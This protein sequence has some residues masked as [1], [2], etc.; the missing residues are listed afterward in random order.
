MSRRGGGEA[1]IRWGDS[2]SPAV[3]VAPGPLLE[4]QGNQICNISNEEPEN[5]Q[6]FLGLSNPNT[7][8][9]S[10]AVSFQ[11][12]FGIR[13]GVGSA[14][15]DFSYLL[16]FSTLITAITED[17]FSLGVPWAPGVPY[18]GPI[19][20]ATVPFNLFKS[21]ALFPTRDLFVTPY[22]SAVGSGAWMATATAMA[23]PQV[24]TTKPERPP[25]FMPAGFHEEPLRYRR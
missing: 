6:L 24:R 25:Q 21:L 7:Y 22:L 1:T 3:N 14:T 12:R 17:D 15:F 23:A 11:C 10:G 19:P 4:V 18:T 5:F 20:T 13:L 9:T 8:P 16:Y 2:V